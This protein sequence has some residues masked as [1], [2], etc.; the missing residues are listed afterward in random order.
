MS[1]SW[2]GLDDDLSSLLASLEMA[3]EREV[4]E[5]ERAYSEA[6]E[7]FR[8]ASQPL[9]DLVQDLVGEEVEAV[10]GPYRLSGELTRVY[11]DFLLLHTDR[12]EVLLRLE[13]V[14]ALRLR[15][16]P[17]VRASEPRRGRSGTAAEESEGGTEEQAAPP[18]EP[19][20]LDFAAA[21]RH[22][23][24]GRRQVR[25]GLVNGT[26][27]SGT[28]DAVGLDYLLLA[29]HPAGRPRREKEVTKRTALSLASLAWVELAEGRGGA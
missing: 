11:R 12:G 14:A 1:T 26:V 24:R 7:R 6:E 29:E 13:A 4:R 20:S 9:I 28:P 19:L 18:E 25:I 8:R 3:L 27:L 21:L 22:L 23:S 10:L 17:E 5:E 16:P 15:R 2:R